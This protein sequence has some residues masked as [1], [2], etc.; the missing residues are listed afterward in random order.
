MRLLFSF[1]FLLCCIST[2]AQQIIG[3]PWLPL[4]SF[5]PDSSVVGWYIA[6]DQPYTG[7]QTNFPVIDSSGHSLHLSTSGNSPADSPIYSVNG[8]ASHSVMNFNAVNAVYTNLAASAMIDG[9]TIVG[10]VNTLTNFSHPSGITVFFL[11]STDSKMSIWV[12]TSGSNVIWRATGSTTT[13]LVTNTLGNYQILSMRWSA[14][15]GIPSIS[16]NDTTTVGSAGTTGNLLWNTI[17]FQGGA[18]NQV[19][20]ILFFT[21]KISDVKL[22]ETR[23]Y[24]ANKYGISIAP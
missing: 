15:D 23:N 11:R 21:N 4:S 5:T 9:C 20:E 7:G 13:A 12:K 8:P 14:S 22:T 19:A 3:R 17:Q 18:T 16:D 2:D 1:L 6:D 24:L 10:C